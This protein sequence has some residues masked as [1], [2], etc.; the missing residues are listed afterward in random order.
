MGKV[1]KLVA[2]RSGM[3]RFRMVV[4]QVC[5]WPLSVPTFCSMGKVDVEVSVHV[6]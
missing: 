5:A 1:I 3:F 4:L 6:D 2:W